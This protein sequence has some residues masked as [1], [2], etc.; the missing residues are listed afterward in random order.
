MVNKIIEKMS[1]CAD[2]QKP[3]AETRIYST[4]KIGETIKDD[5]PCMGLQIGAW[6]GTKYAMKKASA[7]QMK[8]FFEKR[9]KMEH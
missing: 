7:Y 2:G 8:K 9:W 4:Q 5:A 3:K 1:K 6:E